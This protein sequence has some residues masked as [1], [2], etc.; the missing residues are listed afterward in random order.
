MQGLTTQQQNLFIVI[1]KYELAS[2]LQINQ[3]ITNLIKL[4]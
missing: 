4:N 3:R 2:H 1:I